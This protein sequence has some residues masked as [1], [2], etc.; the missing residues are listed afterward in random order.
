MRRPRIQPRRAAPHAPSLNHAAGRSRHAALLSRP[1]TAT[2]PGVHPAADRVTPPGLA[3]A[4]TKHRRRFHSLRPRGRHHA[5]TQDP[6]ARPPPGQH[7]LCRCSWWRGRRLRFSAP[8]TGVDFPARQSSLAASPS[9]SVWGKASYRRNVFEINPAREQIRE[10]RS[11]RWLA[12][13]CVMTP[14]RAYRAMMAQPKALAGPGG[15]EGHRQQ[16]QQV[17]DESW[18]SR[19]CG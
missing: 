13:R 16:E 12:A 11:C 14:D 6:L 3:A 17:R 19:A 5:R 2:N 10:Q 1:S 18:A 7:P 9:C 15:R 8:R 4:I